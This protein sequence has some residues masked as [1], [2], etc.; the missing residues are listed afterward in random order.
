MCIEK[1]EAEK[2]KRTDTFKDLNDFLLTTN[3]LSLQVTLAME[4][5]FI[6][7]FGLAL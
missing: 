3:R 7:Y 6:F 1:L 4:M 2:S 5:Y